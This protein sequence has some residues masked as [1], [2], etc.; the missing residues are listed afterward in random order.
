MAKA[1]LLLPLVYAATS[2]PS[3]LAG[4]TAP[5][6]EEDED[7]DSRGIAKPSTKG[8]TFRLGGAACTRRWRGGMH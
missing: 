8:A 6:E 2:V 7:L 1:S 4:T 3:A 5:D